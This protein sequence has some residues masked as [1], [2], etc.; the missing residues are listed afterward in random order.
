[1][2]GADLAEFFVLHLEQL[3]EGRD[4]HGGLEQVLVA[5]GDER[6][7][8]FEPD[9]GVELLGVVVQQ[10]DEVIWKEF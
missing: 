4:R 3:Q 9:F 6:S 5:D 8:D 7:D 1:M 2:R 10:L